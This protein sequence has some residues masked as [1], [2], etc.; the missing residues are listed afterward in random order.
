[1]C[2]RFALTTNEAELVEEFSI[3]GVSSLRDPLPANWNI[4]PTEEIYIIRHG[5]SD[6]NSRELTHVSWGLIAPWSKNESDAVKSQSQA[7]N[8]RSESI[9]EKPTFKRA[10]SRSRCLIP[11]TGYYEWATELG[12]YK[13]KQPVFISRDDSRLL[14][15][16]GIYDRWI[17]PQGE[18]RESAAIIT[19]EAVEPLATVHHRM[20]LFL[21]QS[22]WSDWLSPQITDM[23]DV[24]SLMNVENPAEHLRFWPVK[25]LVNSIRNNGPELI[26]KIEL[27]EPETLF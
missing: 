19:R 10:F 4:K 5:E 17:S 18:I 2:G 26:A 12:R 11:A 21:P 16:A 3:T 23:H 14:A 22:T 8:A 9:H 27:G 13:T 1:M 7:I 15:F 20:P 25:D 24:R 6:T